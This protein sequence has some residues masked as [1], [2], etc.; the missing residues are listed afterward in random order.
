MVIVTPNT[1][2]SFER[3]RFVASSAETSIWCPVFKAGSSPTRVRINESKSDLFK[4][5]LS[6]FIII[7][8]AGRVVLLCVFK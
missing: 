1:V 7:S 5:V 4:N 6:I 8:S 3:D 2:V